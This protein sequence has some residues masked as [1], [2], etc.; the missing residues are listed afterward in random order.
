MEGIGVRDAILPRPADRRAPAGKSYRIF[1][2]L[3]V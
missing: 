1:N 2:Y 3:L